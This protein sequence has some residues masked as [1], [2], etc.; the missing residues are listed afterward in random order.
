MVT[1]YYVRFEVNSR[2]TNR[3]KTL[4]DDCVGARRYAEDKLCG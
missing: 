2:N 1:D 3:S 4:P